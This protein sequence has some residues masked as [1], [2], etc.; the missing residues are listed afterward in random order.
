MNTRV[1]QA[2][3][4]QFSE[5][6]HTYGLNEERPDENMADQFGTYQTWD[7]F[8]DKNGAMVTLNRFIPSEVGERHGETPTYTMEFAS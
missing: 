6:L 4:A 8:V 7:A 2:T 3:A 1:E 5:L